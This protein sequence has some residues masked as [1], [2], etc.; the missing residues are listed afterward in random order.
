VISFEMALLLPI[1]FLVGIIAAMI[2]VGRSGHATVLES[3][4]NS[5]QNVGLSLRKEGEL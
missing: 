5:V 3:D 1:A 4:A 2:G